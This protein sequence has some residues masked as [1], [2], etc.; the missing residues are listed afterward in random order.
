[1]GWKLGNKA[2]LFQSSNRIGS[3]DLIGLIVGILGDQTHRSDWEGVLLATR[4]E[5]VGCKH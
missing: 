3:I 4:Q 2:A 5:K 1:M